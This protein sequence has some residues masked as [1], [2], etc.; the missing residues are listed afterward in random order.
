MQN[1]FLTTRFFTKQRIR[2]RYK[3][4]I[5]FL[6]GKL[7][8]N[9]KDQS[10]FFFTLPKAASCYMGGV[11]KKLAK[12]AGLIPIDLDSYF[13]DIGKHREWLNTGRTLRRVAYQ[14]LGYFFGPFRTI[15][16]GITN[17]NPY[18]ILIV[19]RDPRDVIVSNYFSIAY[20]HGYPSLVSKRRLKE[21]KD[22]RERIK[23]QTIDEF[24][25]N[26]INQTFPKLDYRKEYQHYINLKT[27]PNV[28]LLK[29]EDIV[30][31]F[32]NELEKVLKFLKL[33]VGQKTIDEI[34]K[35]GNFRVEREDIYSHKRQVSS[36][37]HKK[38][39]RKDTIVQL[40]KAYAEI[41]E[42]LNYSF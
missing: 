16:K 39:L 37:D 20:S 28:L 25:I 19:V 40:D 14:P 11:M 9:S 10:V 13:F 42:K 30:V 33:N 29:Y 15:H 8:S 4:E 38:K 23:N 24:A 6:K 21:I 41:L 17:L 18:K 2:N 27:R 12:G 36:G 32:D 26:C 31:N 3:A 34:L 1:N 7:T 5:L 22:A 35:T